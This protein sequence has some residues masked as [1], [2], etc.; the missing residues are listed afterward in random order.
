MM[1][2]FPVPLLLL[3]LKM[4]KNFP[5]AKQHLGESVHRL[6]RLLQALEGPCLV[7]AQSYKDWQEAALN[8]HSEG[9]QDSWRLLA[10]IS[11]SSMTGELLCGEASPG[12]L[13]DTLK[14]LTKR[15]K[16]QFY[17][18]IENKTKECQQK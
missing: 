1:H 14:H 3:S 4:D 5:E 9:P 6:K 17:Y 15:I 11:F 18:Q 7:L 10:L 13:E 16:I 12:P 2:T 8:S